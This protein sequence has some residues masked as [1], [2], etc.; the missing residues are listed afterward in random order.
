MERGYT[1]INK[2]AVEEYV[3]LIK[4]TYS[5]RIIAVYLYGSVAR[6]EAN[7]DSDIDILIL[8][9]NYTIDEYEHIVGSAWDVSDKYN[10]DGAN[11]LISPLLMIEQSLNANIPIKENLERDGVML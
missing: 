3:S 10:A 2:Q 6:A 7:E 9:K 1:G 8:L 11:I 4:S 5:D